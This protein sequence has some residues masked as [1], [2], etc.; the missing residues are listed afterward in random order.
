MERT[1]DEACEGNRSSRPDDFNLRTIGKGIS[2]KILLAESKVSKHIY[3]V[4]IIKKGLLLQNDELET[5]KNEK[6]VLLIVAKESHPGI[7]L[8]VFP[9]LI[10][11]LGYSTLRPRMRSAISSLL[12]SQ[13]IRPRFQGTQRLCSKVYPRNSQQRG[14]ERAPSGAEDIMRHT[15]FVNVKWVD[16][17]HKRLKPSFVS[18]VENAF[19]T[20]TFRFRICDYNPIN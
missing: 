11:P 6:E 1:A 14:S 5:V 4:K 3:A 2:A 15:F 7:D 19:D 8:I 10:K 17:Y 13:S 9:L 18:N 20:S 12:T 16:M